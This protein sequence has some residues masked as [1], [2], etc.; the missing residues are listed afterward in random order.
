MKKRK[1]KKK[2]LQFLKPLKWL[3][4]GMGVKRWLLFSFFGIIFIVAGGQFL[5]GPTVVF[6]IEGIILLF[7]GIVIVTIGI[8]RILS[9]FITVLLP[10]REEELVDLVYQKKHLER[11]YK[12]VAI[13]G[14]TGLST[15]LQGLKQYTSNI[16]AI[17]TVADDGGSSGQLRRD[18]D[19]LPPGDIRSCLVALADTEPLMS[20]LFQYRFDG[21]TAFAGH[22]FGNIFILAMSKVIEDFEEAVKQSSKILAIRGQVVPSTLKKV[23]LV[24]ELED[25]TTTCGE[26]EITKRENPSSIKR[27][28]LEPPDCEPTKSALDAINEADVIILGPGS[29]YTSI[30]PNL[31]IGSM[32]EAINNSN[33]IKIYACNIMTQ[34]GE[35][36]SYKASTHLDAILNQTKLN[37]VD[38]CIVDNSNI[39]K[40]LQESYAD[41]N[42]VK[43]EADLDGI[44]N[45]GAT[46]I[47]DNLIRITKLK[48]DEKEVIRHNARRLAKSMIDIISI[49]KTEAAHRKS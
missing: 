4:P 48:G 31:L 5:S 25:G 46:P 22:S 34:H 41:E 29:L 14:G 45:V 39:P 15:L 6:R 24:A 9:T 32:A 28:S 40:E 11:G 10:Q 35:T 21:N 18:F 47:E 2:V 20:D 1:I 37:K 23:R 44:K 7:V 13:G 42:S 43:V 12:I 19:V 49:A 8:K 17:V 30:I 3:Y 38:Y 33:A 26:S 16:T 27:L 36:D